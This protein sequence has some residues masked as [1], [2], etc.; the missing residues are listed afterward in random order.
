M[1]WSYLPHQRENREKES[2]IGEYRVSMGLTVKEFCEK[3]KIG[4]GEYCALNNGM[5]SPIYEIKIGIRPS[6]LRICE[7]LNKEPEDL[8]PRY[9]CKFEKDSDF[10]DGQLHEILCSKQYD[11]DRKFMR[12]DIEKAMDGLSDRHRY[13]LK[14]R[15]FDELSLGEI[16]EIIGVSMARVGQLEAKALR[17]IR[18]PSRSKYILPWKDSIRCR[19]SKREQ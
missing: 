13:I 4:P 2:L 19:P 12:S 14:L 18:H 11:E 17:L 5:Q 9:F 16:G 15:F 3:V 7:F 10:T 6:V 8:F 1:T